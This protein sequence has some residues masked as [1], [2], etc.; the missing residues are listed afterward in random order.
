M[1]EGSSLNLS[2]KNSLMNYTSN[3]VVFIR[4]IGEKP[5]FLSYITKKLLFGGLTE[6]G[7]TTI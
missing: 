4:S 7:Q 6:A 5:D 3:I 2:Q 1:L